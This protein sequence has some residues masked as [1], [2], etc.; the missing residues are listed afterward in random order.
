MNRLIPILLEF[1]WH[2]N[3]KYEKKK[4]KKR[5]FHW[6]KFTRFNDFK[7]SN[8]PEIEFQCISSNEGVKSV[9]YMYIYTL[10]Q[11]N[12]RANVRRRSYLCANTPSIYITLLFV[13]FFF[14]SFVSLTFPQ[15]TSLHYI[16]PT[17]ILCVIC[18]WT[19]LTI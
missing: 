18:T 13:S 11:E 2:F 6:E 12:T 17:H 19:L 10:S 8:T 15:L 5:I 16:L 14:L 3:R 1:S 9:T 7:K 4:K